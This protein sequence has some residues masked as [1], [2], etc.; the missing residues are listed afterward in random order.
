MMEIRELDDFAEPATVSVE[1]A[2][3]AALGT[4][5]ERT[6][7]AGTDDY[8][9][10]WSREVLERRPLMV[11]AVVMDGETHMWVR[12]PG[13][14][15]VLRAD[16]RHVLSTDGQTVRDLGRAEVELEDRMLH[17]ITAEV[18][19]LMQDRDAAERFSTDIRV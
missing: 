4:M 18:S 9:E 17:A 13:E 6:A 3:A 12:E 14:D 19:W 15:G 2:L 8:Y 16:I 10:S 1:H 7:P 11:L 5:R